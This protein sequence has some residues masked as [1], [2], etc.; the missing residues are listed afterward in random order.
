M[1]KSALAETDLTSC[2]YSIVIPA[3]DEAETIGEL[4]TELRD[5]LP[6]AEILVV[7]DGSIDDTASVSM[8]SGALVYRHPVSLGNGAAIKS[9]AR[10]VSGDAIIFMDGDGQHRV[11][12]VLELISKFESGWDM[13]VGSRSGRKAQ[14]SAA[15]WVGNGFYNWY[16]SALT[17]VQILDLTSGLRIVNRLKFLEILHLLPNKFSYPTTSTIAFIKLGYSVN[18]HEVDVKP[19]KGGSHINIFRDGVRFFAII[20]KVTILF[21]PFKFLMPISFLSALLGLMMYFLAALEGTYRFT[22]GMALLFTASFFS[23]SVALIAEQMTM[24]LYSKK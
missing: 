5:T 7:D 22:N 11:S 9:G 2:K 21:S 17:G 18:F 1:E 12:C 20:F 8:S 19:A 24:L 16:A 23:F 13:I 10:K 6:R 14:S 4:I 15:R 3:R